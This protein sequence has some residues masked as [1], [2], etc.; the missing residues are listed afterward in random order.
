MCQKFGALVPLPG[1]VV[2]A[3]FVLK[4]LPLTLIVSGVIGLNL[5]GGGH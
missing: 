5:A 2:V 3:W 4:L 1:G